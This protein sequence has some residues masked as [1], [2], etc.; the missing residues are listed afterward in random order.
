M[1][2]VTSTI[3][4]TLRKATRDD[5]RAIERLLTGN[6]LPTVGV[7]ESVTDFT[8][9]EVNG[10]IVG[11]AGLELCGSE[12]A[13]LRSAAVEQQWRS[14]GVGRKLVER[15]IGDAGA[16]GLRALYLLTTTAEGY[17]PKFGFTRT[18]RDTVPPEIRRTAEFTDACPASAAVMTLQ[19]NPGGGAR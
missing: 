7:A 6:K 17:F 9:A 3:Q 10:E 14:S 13:L 19:L 16:R 1:K 4:P 2:P 18:E 5:L 12:Y 8:V 11:V 15:V